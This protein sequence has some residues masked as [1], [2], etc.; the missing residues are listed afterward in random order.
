MQLGYSFFQTLG[1]ELSACEYGRQA[2]EE[3]FRPLQVHSVCRHACVVTSHIQPA[4][5]EPSS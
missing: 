3:Y 2:L 5:R 1:A 4:H